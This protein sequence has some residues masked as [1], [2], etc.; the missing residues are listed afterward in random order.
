MSIKPQHHILGQLV[1][2]QRDKLQKSEHSESYAN[3]KI[4]RKVCSLTTAVPHIK[5][6]DS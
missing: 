4:F 5:Q 1:T 6:A 2:E 3:N